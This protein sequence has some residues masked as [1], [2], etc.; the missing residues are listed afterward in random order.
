MPVVASQRGEVALDRVVTPGEIR[1]QTPFEIQVLAR[2]QPDDG[3]PDRVGARLTV[4]R[5]IGDRSE[6]VAE[7]HVDLAP[8]ANVFTVPQEVDDTGFLTYEATIVSDDPSCDQF[9]QNNTSTSYTQIEGPGRALL[10]VDWHRPDELAGFADSL[11]ASGLEVT[12]QRSDR[13]FT[14]LAELQGYDVV[15][16]GNVPRTGGADAETSDQFT[17]EQVHLL[18]ENTRRMGCGLVMLGGADS[19][20]AGGWTNTEV[21]AAMPVDFQIK[22]AKML[23]VGALM[24]V[25]D[26]SGSMD[27]EKLRLSKSAAIEAVKVLGNRDSIGVISF[28]STAT[29]VVPLQT[30]D[31]RARIVRQISA[32]SAGGGTDMYPAML[33]GFRAL[34][35]SSAAA[36]HMIVLTDGQT[37]PADFQNLVRKVRQQG[38]TVSA[39]AVGPDADVARL[40]EIATL[41][42]GKFYRVNSPRAIPRIFMYEARRVTRPVIYENVNG[43]TPAIVAGHEILTG[44][45][46][47]LPPMTGYVMT[48][49]KENLLVEKPILAPLPSGQDNVV[50]ATWSYG[51][52]RA[53]ALTTDLGSTWTSAWRGWPDREKFLLQLVRWAMRPTESDGHLYVATE[54]DGQM[55]KITLTALTEAGDFDNGLPATAYALGPNGQTVDAVL[56]QTAPGNYTGQIDV[57]AAGSYF[58]AVGTGG[59]RPPV[60][61]GVD[62]GYSAEFRRRGEDLD[63]LRTLAA[64]TPRGGTTG[65]VFDPINLVEQA[66]P[67]DQKSDPTFDPFRRDLPRGR[68]EQSGWPLALLLAAALF[69]STWPTDGSAGTWARSANGSPRDSTAPQVRPT[70]RWS[71]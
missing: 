24:I 44:I 26:R 52:G 30:A 70:R 60:R 27:G 5:L 47:P 65:R 9:L 4:R 28:D 43:I 37:E 14:N 20:G 58:L 45:A 25:I 67:P 42:G 29:T 22:N 66:S 12:L 16:L 6:L 15:I 50:L 57:D 19:F 62:V 59:D 63:L 61:T 51:L 40:T 18:A 39:V 53:V 56:T 55:I 48:T 13:L 23:A 68:S 11:R 3:S 2:Y 41:G 34:E 7:R 32:I 64:V 38:I 8:G 31:R 1:K 10:I 35:R 49:P 21:E 46:G 54:V 33:D 36:K 71:G 17:D 69:C